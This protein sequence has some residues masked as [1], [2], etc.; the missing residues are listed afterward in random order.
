[1]EP[2]PILIMAL[3]LILAANAIHAADICPP[4]ERIIEIKDYERGV[5]MVVE[6]CENIGTFS[7]GGLYD[8]EFKK[9]TFSYPIPWKGTFITLKVDD[10]LYSNSINPEEISSEKENFLDAY[11]TM[12]PHRQGDTIRMSWRLPGNVE[13]EEVLEAMED[14]TRISLTARNEG[15]VK[16]SFGARLHLD[17]MLGENDGA[18]IY[19]PGDGLKSYEKEYQGSELN[20]RYWKAYNKADNPSVIAT[21]VLKG[22]NLTY[23]DRLIVANWKQSMKSSWDYTVEPSTSILGDSALILY[24]TQVDME[25]GETVT[26][27]TSYINGEPI[28]S[29]SKGD[30][31]IAEIVTDKIDGRYCPG[32]GVYIKTDV[33]SRETNNEGS[34]KLR[35]KNKA[36]DVIYE[37]TRDTGVVEADSINSIGYSFKTPKDVSRENLKVTAALYQDGQEIDNKTIDVLVDERVCTK[38]PIEIKVDW[39]MP[40]VIVVLILLLAVTACFSYNYMINRGEIEVTKT[41]ENEEVNVIVENNT[42][43]KLKDC[44]IEDSIPDGAEVNIITAGVHRKG[45]KLTWDIGEIPPKEHAILEYKIKKQ[46]ILPNA[47]FR[48]DS[49]KMESE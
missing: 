20:Y 4:D 28:L 45:N 49:G 21:G 46:G 25:P 18:P 40:L 10:V 27:S 3:V 22:E 19:I 48:W 8:G 39:L 31:G 42:R 47:L 5:G 14:G 12:L 24:Y 35:V 9:L 26:F 11:V 1:M 29:A 2:K 38:P 23:P 43:S 16:V 34:L 15:E 44:V 41:A 33:L 30:F 7:L 32:D 36:G 13:V 6:N 17:T 37:K